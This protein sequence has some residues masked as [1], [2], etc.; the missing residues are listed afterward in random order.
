M[1]RINIGL[2]RNTGGL[3]PV[4]E[5]LFALRRHN[6]RVARWR[7]VESDSEPTLTAELEG[8]LSEASLLGLC[9]ELAQDCVAVI[10]SRG[11]EL[12]GPKAAAWGPFNPAYFFTLEGE[13]LAPLPA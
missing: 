9:D 5:A 6:V 8:E 2:H 7:V 11:G 13:R 1:I 4:P 10:D 3:I 12:Y